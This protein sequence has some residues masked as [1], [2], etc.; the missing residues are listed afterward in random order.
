MQLFVRP[1]PAASPAR[2]RILLSLWRPTPS[3]DTYVWDTKRIGLVHTVVFSRSQP[4][5]D[6]HRLKL[7]YLAYGKTPENL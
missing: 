6:L 5:K 7:S 2:A 4:Q 1:F 3:S